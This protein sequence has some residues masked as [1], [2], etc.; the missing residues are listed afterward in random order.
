MLNSFDNLGIQ[1]ERIQTTQSVDEV[2]ENL[3]SQRPS[4][5]ICYVKPS[6][7]DI[8]RLIDEH[9]KVIPN[10]LNRYFLSFSGNKSIFTFAQALEEEV[11]GYIVEP[12]TQTKVQNKIQNIVRNKNN[13]TAYQVVLGQIQAKLSE[14]DYSAA[15][16][17]CH[18]A[19]VL[20][21]RPCMAFYLLA[22]IQME[23]KENSEAIKT[24]LQG[25]K[26]NKNHY[27]CLLLLHDL[28]FS[29]SNFD[30][31]YRVLKKVLETFP[32]SMA[33]M[34]DVFRM[35][36]SM[37]KFDEIEGYCRK[38]LREEKNDLDIIRFCTS[39]LIV[40]A[41]Q[42]LDKKNENTGIAL[43]KETLKYSK[44]DPKVLRNIFKCYLIFGLYKNAD[45]ILP[46]F[47]QDD[48]SGQDYSS[49]CLP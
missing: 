43:L 20:H 29:Q 5:F 35:G 7:H 16:Q 42:I 23:E 21:P 39:G 15:K 17:L 12:Y 4:F 38:V 32:L 33:R 36:I 47:K 24:L 22:K 30:K 49:L 40:C 44:S 11:D 10:H 48:R 1:R 46:I 13:P 45:K 27:R 18:S 34:F 2:I 28:Y 37:S 14:E 8:F 41:M 31:A 26:F 6:D 25:L 19:M 9:K 3:K